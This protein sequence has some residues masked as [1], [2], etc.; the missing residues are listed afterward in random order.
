MIINM[1]KRT[2][3]IIIKMNQPD[4]QEELIDKEKSARQ[5]I[6]LLLLVVTSL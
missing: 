6:I 4:L 1:A 3:L 2:D 5:G